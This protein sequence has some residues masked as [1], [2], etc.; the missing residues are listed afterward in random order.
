LISNSV[1]F[2][3][4][5][6]LSRCIS[7][8]KGRGC[9]QK[10]PKLPDPANSRFRIARAFS[11]KTRQSVFTRRPSAFNANERH[12]RIHEWLGSA[13]SKSVSKAL[14]EA[15]Y[16]FDNILVSVVKCSIILSSSTRLA[17]MRFAA[18]SG[19]APALL[20]PFLVVFPKFRDPGC[21]F[22]PNLHSHC[23]ETK[24]NFFASLLNTE[25]HHLVGRGQDYGIGVTNGEGINADRSPKICAR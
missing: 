9:K 4:A 10:R 22:D 12:G 23:Q 18:S 5:I 17:M 24:Q 11:Q 7:D 3:F 14:K 19:Q 25:K 2:A 15:V 20:R 1:P 16:R 13:F 8:F 6:D 21:P